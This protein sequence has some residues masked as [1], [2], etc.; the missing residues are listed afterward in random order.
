MC[1]YAD[2]QMGEI[3]SNT[4]QR[5]MNNE[6]NFDVRHSKFDVRYYKEGF[7]KTGWQCYY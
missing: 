5:M 7:L 4:E 3:I 6:V 2:V 1:G